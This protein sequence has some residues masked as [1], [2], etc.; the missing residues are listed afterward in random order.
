VALR[1]RFGVRRGAG[2]RSASLHARAARHSGA[3]SQKAGE[4][5]GVRVSGDYVYFGASGA[6]IDGAAI[7]CAALL[8]AAGGL[9][10]GLFAR[11]ALASQQAKS[12]FFIWQARPGC[13]RH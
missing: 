4:I 12:D 13:A 9:L 6:A 5:C 10:G 8:G 11:L 1:V 3:N 7:V 2:C